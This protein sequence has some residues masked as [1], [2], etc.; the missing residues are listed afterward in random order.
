[1]RADGPIGLF[2]S[3]VGGLTVVSRVVQAL[4]HE[5]IL[6]FGDTAHLPYG[7]RPLD[8]VR[9]YA[10]RIGRYL[11]AQGAKAVVVACNTS[12]AA[13]LEAMQADLPVPVLGTVD[14]GV[15]AALKVARN[16]CVG[17]LATQATV[18]AG[19]YPRA[20]ERAGARMEVVEQPCPEFVTLVEAGVTRGSE[21]LS[22]AE[23]YCT[24][25]RARAID[26][27]VL[28]CTHYPYLAGVIR[29]VI[30]PD[31]SL[32][33]P[34][35]ELARSLAHRLDECGLRR[36]DGDPPTHRYLVS[37]DPSAFAESARRL[38]CRDIA[39]EKV[40]IFDAED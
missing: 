35:E 28:G 36:P 19:A 18:L 33:D 12:T 14:C 26:T 4:P 40:D 22:A 13:A 10:L 11:V 15:R 23:R 31:V 8:E 6:Y 30:G 38:L 2:D 16:G 1:M 20:F 32:V 37:G 29:Q 7:M 21:A 39:V 27:V 9:A 24:A 17:V 5:S 3:G 34:A 25:V